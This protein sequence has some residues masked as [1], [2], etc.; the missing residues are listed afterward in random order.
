MSS[1]CL[2]A[3]WVHHGFN[4]HHSLNSSSLHVLGAP[5]NA[6]RFLSMGPN[7]AVADHRRECPILQPATHQ[8]EARRLADVA[9]RSSPRAGCKAVACLSEG[10]ASDSRHR[11]VRLG[12]SAAILLHNRGR[13]ALISQT[14]PAARAPA[15]RREMARREAMPGLRA[16]GSAA[17]VMRCAIGLPAC[18]SRSRGYCSSAT[19]FKSPL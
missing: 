5:V 13:R 11:R 1:Q 16:V 10:S 14:P 12:H 8:I 18:K 15:V 9:H 4:E 17:G 2:E 7:K 3:I 6:H 19:P